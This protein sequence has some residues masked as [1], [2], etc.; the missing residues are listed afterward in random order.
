MQNAISKKTRPSSSDAI[1]DE[2]HMKESTRLY[3][4][5]SHQAQSLTGKST[6]FQQLIPR[7][8]PLI[9]VNPTKS[10]GSQ[11]QNDIQHRAREIQMAVL[12]RNSQKFTHNRPHFNIQLN[13]INP[14]SP[15]CVLFI[16]GVFAHIY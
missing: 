2:S 8:I 10:H 12:E 6:T 3:T 16:R 14:L 11:G 15:L 9:E 1:L 5:N 4:V 13:Q 7:Y